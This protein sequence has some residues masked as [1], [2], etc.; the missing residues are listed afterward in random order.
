MGPP[1]ELTNLSSWSD[2]FK[3]RFAGEPLKTIE[4]SFGSQIVRGEAVLTRDGIEGGAIYALS[5]TLRDAIAVAG[6]A[7]LRIALRPDLDA[8]RLTARLSAL[9]GKQ[10]FSTFLRKAAGL[11]PVVIGLLHAATGGDAFDQRVLRHAD[12][13]ARHHADRQSVTACNAID[14]VLHG[15]SVGVDIDAGR[16]QGSIIPCGGE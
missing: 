15:T 10:S 6:H 8:D 14:L 11:S 12:Q 1:T 13:I 16:A 4:L 7:T 2:V 5:A 3:D 9:R